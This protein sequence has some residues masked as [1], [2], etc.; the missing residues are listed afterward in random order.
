MDGPGQV[1]HPDYIEPPRILLATSEGILVGYYDWY[2]HEGYGR[3][4]APG[5]SAW[6]DH[7]GGRTYGVS[8]WMPLPVAPSSEG[9]GEC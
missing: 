8:H 3:G 5:E 4:A 9:R 6:R 1:T 7:D 2:Y